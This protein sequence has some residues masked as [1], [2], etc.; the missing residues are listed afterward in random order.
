L[1]Q[2]D[3]AAFLAIC[4]RF[5]A[6]RASARAFPPFNPPSLPSATAA[7]FLVGTGGTGAAC[8]VECWTML[9]AVSF[10]SLLERLGMTQPCADSGK[11]QVQSAIYDFKLYHY[12]IFKTKLWGFCSG[13]K[14][15][16]HDQFFPVIIHCRPSRH[17]ARIRG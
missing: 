5:L 3:F 2:R 15:Q 11:I 8:P 16:L 7:G 17:I 9:K 12:R 14:C 10:M 1:D 6:V 4:L 13:K